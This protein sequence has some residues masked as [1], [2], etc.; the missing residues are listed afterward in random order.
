ML[1]SNED[2][3]QEFNAEEFYQLL[4]SAEYAAKEGR[5]GIETGI[6]QY[7]VQQLGLNKDPVAEMKSLSKQKSSSSESETDGEEKNCNAD[8]NPVSEGDFV[9]TKLISNGA[10]G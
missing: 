10:Y 3:L 6:P 8:R 9:V 5:H 7:I 2:F 4:E 1:A